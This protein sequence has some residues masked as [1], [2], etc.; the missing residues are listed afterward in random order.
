MRPR[1]K[2]GGF[3]AQ[4]VECRVAIRCEFGAEPDFGFRP[5]TICLAPTVMDTQFLDGRPLAKA[6]RNFEPYSA[7]N[8]ARM[9]SPQTASSLAPTQATRWLSSSVRPRP[10]KD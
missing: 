5:A 9:V 10:S 8:T 1:R 2:G 7:S 3:A 4:K 6:P